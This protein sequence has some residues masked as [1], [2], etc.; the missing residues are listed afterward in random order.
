MQKRVI[1]TGASG[2]VGKGVLLEC[3]DDHRIEEILIINRRSIHFSHS[4]VKELLL[5]D[6]S[7]LAEVEAQLMNYDACFYCMGISAAGMSEEKYTHITYSITKE[8]VDILYHLNPKMVFNYVSG[9][10]TDSSEKGRMMWA[11]VKGSTENI[12]LN[13]GFKDAYAF[14]PGFIIPEKGV[15]S[16]TKLYQTFYTILK[17]VFPLLKKMKSVTTTTIVGKA[18]IQTVFFPSHKKVLRN[19]D[20]NTLV[21]NLE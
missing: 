12:V 17:P 5:P 9:E 19:K 7:M 15:T 11:R 18:M 8:F 14:R 4:K 20:F 2:M 6:F 3:I 16:K 10:G 1:I 21:S 13:K